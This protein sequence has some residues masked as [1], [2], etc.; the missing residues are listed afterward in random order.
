MTTDEKMTQIFKALTRAGKPAETTDVLAIARALEL[1]YT[2]TDVSDDILET[3]IE[4]EA[5][6]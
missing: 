3:R 2:N 6:K 1:N 5:S 4:L